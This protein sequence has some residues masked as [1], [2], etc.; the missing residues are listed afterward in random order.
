MSFHTI[1]HGKWILIGEHSVLRGSP[2]L[3]FPLRSRTMELH[4]E[5]SDS[6]LQV[7]F[8]GE[9]GREMEGLFWAVL[10][11]AC[12][13]MRVPRSMIR[14]KLTLTSNI[15]IGAGL[16]ASAAFCVAMTRWF[17]FAG[18]LRGD[19]LYEF[20]RTLEDLFH[21][22]SSG[23]D[24][25][26]AISDQ[27]LHFERN[28]RRVALVPKWTPKWFIS[29]TGQRGITSEAV[30]KVK[31]LLSEDPLRGQALDQQMREAALTCEQA[32]ALDEASGFALLAASITKAAE[33]FEAWGL[34]E[35]AVSEHLNVLREAGAV[36]VKPTGSGGGGYVLSLWR[37]EPP[38]AVRPLLIPC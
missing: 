36:A 7:S 2:A 31:R 21:G 16:G 33:C 29:S 34:S 30:N 5:A 6:A 27:G 12:D 15:P 4:Y 19:D 13:L 37:E 10:E 18:W 8:E 23:L 22:E 14:G 25:A 17:R 20:A 1:T 38:A 28:G 3:V 35:G 9:S 26:V 32:L 24:I 11:R